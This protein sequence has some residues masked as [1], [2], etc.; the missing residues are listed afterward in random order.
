MKKRG[1]GKGLSEM[2]VAELLSGTAVAVP[3]SLETEL[4]KLPINA[5]QPGKYQ[6]RRKM[7]AERLEELA[8]SIRSQGIIQPIVVRK[9]AD[10]YEIIAGER[11]WRAAQMVELKEVPVV[12]RNINDESALAMSLIENIQRQD[13]NVMD[14]AYALMRL[15]EEFKMTHQEVATAVGKSRASV[16]NILRLLKLHPDVRSMVEQ[17]L[18][19]MGH[20]RAL[21]T[22]DCEQ[23]NAV[24]NA[25]VARSLSVRETEEMIRKLQNQKQ[26]STPRPTVENSD[27]QRLQENLSTRLKTPVSIKQ[28]AKGRGKLIIHYDSV[29]Q[30]DDILQHIQ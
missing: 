7:N 24:A 27:V 3:R 20:A 9:I 1:L 13:L 8:N 12:I 23:Q 21:L 17:G 6:P 19:D 16:T 15:I 18:L 28:S 30:L 11:R 10:G 14:E 22:L 4:T 2:G 29:D 5:I 26:S 25:T